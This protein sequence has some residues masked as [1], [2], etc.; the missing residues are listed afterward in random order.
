MAN[1]KMVQCSEEDLNILMA[2]QRAKGVAEALKPV[3]SVQATG[4]FSTVRFGGTTTRDAGPPAS[5]TITI[6]AGP[7]NGFA[8]N[9]GGDMVVAGY[10]A[11]TKATGRHTNLAKPNETRNGETYLISGMALHP[12]PTNDA[13]LQALIWQNAFLSLQL[14]TTTILP[15]GFLG[16]FP[17][18]A[19]LHGRGSASCVQPPLSSAGPTQID[20]QGNGGTMDPGCY[21]PFPEDSPIIWTPAGKTDSSLQ[22]VFTLP[23]DIELTEDDRAAAAGVLGWQFP[24]TGAPYSY[25]D[26]TARLVGTSIAATS[27]NT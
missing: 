9:V 7:R 24:S 4:Y 8:Y 19:G 20:V 26:I 15:L 18:V 13:F 10:P 27:Q 23:E 14:N 3:K 11:G 6:P 21:F 5:S 17:A 1:G 2:E 25:V 22:L 12:S 16:F